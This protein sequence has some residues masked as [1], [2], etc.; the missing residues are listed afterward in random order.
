MA[1]NGHNAKGYSP[2]KILTWAQKLKIQKRCKQRFY[3]H[4]RVVVCK[5]P[6]QKAA[7]TRKM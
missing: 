4:N 5:Q 6:L 3:D 2:C 7:S 1:K